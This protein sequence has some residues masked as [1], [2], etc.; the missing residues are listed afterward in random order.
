MRN[1]APQCAFGGLG[2]LWLALALTLTL[3]LAPAP[4][5][6]QYSNVN[7]FLPPEEAFQLSVRESGEGYEAAWV[8]APEYY[9]YRKR[10]TVRAGER[11]LEIDPPDGEIITDEFFGRTAVFRHRVAF[12]FKPPPGAD[13]VDVTYQGCADAGLCYTPI[14]KRVTLANLLISPSAAMSSPPSSSSAPP[15][16]PRAASEQEEVFGML[17]DGA[18]LATLAGFLLYGLLLAFS[19]CVLPVLPI[20]LRAL[21]QG[22]QGAPSTPGRA[23]ALSTVYVLAF[24]LVYSLLGVASGLLGESVQA[25][26]QKPWLLTLFA[27]FFVLL[28]LSMFGAFRMQM[29]AVIQT[30]LN[31]ATLGARSGL[32]GSAFLGV[33]SALIVGPCV[34]PALIGALLFIAQTRDALL[35][36]L[37]LFVLGVGMGL[38][39]ILAGTYFSRYLPEPGKVRDTMNII[40]GF[41]MLAVAVWLLERIAP[42]PLI[43]LLAGVWMVVVSVFVFRLTTGERSETSVGVAF[44]RGMCAILALYGALLVVGAAT[45]GHSILR[46][47]GHIA[48]AGGERS[49]GLVFHA[50][51]DLRDLRAKIAEASQSERPTMVDFYAD[52]CIS[53]KE[54]EA[55]TFTDERVQAGLSGARLLRVDV[56]EDNAVNKELLKHFGL[57]GPPALLFFSPAGDEI[58]AARIVGFVPPGQFAEH[59]RRTY[60]TQQAQ[61]AQAGTI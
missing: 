59:I 46:P 33:V 30:R 10:M 57:F 29:P 49:E 42:A 50:A 53:C 41:L 26:L 32:G 40:V 61:Q 54:M 15:A 22:T 3:A 21:T 34:T 48:M 5:E 23:V 31:N 24:S 47:L 19:P 17:K 45:G 1:G 20:L 35:G 36:G 43:L 9:L 56:T 55:F 28:A 6:S 51:T 16:A 7:E 52:W 2:G 25:W 11:A 38:P 44:A 12:G 14:T 58:R 4:A 13:A 39:L 37:A 18:V 8:I 27:A 60:Q